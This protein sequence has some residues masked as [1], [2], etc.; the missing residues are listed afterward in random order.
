MG[1]VVAVDAQHDRRENASAIRQQDARVDLGRDA[2]DARNLAQPFGDAV[3][4]E[5]RV[6]LQGN[7]R[8]V[9]L[10]VEDL[11]L[12]DVAEAGH[13]AADDDDDRNP[14]HDAQDRDARNDRSDGSLRSQVLQ[15][16]EQRKTHVTPISTNR[17]T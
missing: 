8:K 6:A 7:E 1:E 13:H 4:V 2:G 5:D 14:E 9:G 17:T 12:P 16:Q 15:G 10:E 3:L 11:L